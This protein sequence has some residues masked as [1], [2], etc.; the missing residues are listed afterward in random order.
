MDAYATDSYQNVLLSLIQYPLFV[1][2]L[3]DADSNT[4]G[5]LADHTFPHRLTIVSHEFKRA[6][7]LNLHLPAIHWN[8]ITD[9]VGINPPFDPDTLVEVEKGEQRQGFGA[10]KE[11]L[12]G[13]GEA[14]TRKRANRGWNGDTFK[15]EVLEKLPPGE[16]TQRATD[17]VFWDANNGKDRQ[18]VRLGK[19]PW[20]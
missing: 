5:I 19:S 12:Y 10:W 6:R 3:L 9:Y 16:L 20:E 11:D 17:L 2:R 4:D 15:K 14:L 18:V 13:V 8:G 1:Q 7:F